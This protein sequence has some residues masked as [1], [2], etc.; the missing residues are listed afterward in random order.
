MSNIKE[1]PDRSTI[2]EEAGA[3][4]IKLD[5]DTELSLE[6]RQAFKE[7]MGRSPVHREAVKSL[8]QFWGKM[9]VLTELAMPQYGGTSKPAPRPF[10]NFGS[11]TAMAA[12]SLCLVAVILLLQI[13]SNREQTAN[14]LYATAV[15]QQQTIALDDGSTLQLNTNSQVRVDYS[16]Q[17]R[18]IHLLQG[19]AHFTVAKQASRPF[20]VSAGHGLVEAI[21]TA[22][23]VYL[24]NNDIEV[25]ISEGIV[26][27]QSRK[28]ADPAAT[29]QAAVIAQASQPHDLGKLKAGQ[30][31]VIKD[32]VSDAGELQ[33]VA[34]TIKDIS[35]GE[36]ERRL[37]WRKGFIT[38]S[39]APLD[40]VVDEIGRYSQLSIELTDPAMASIKIGGQFKVGEVDTMLESLERN[41]GL[42][43]RRVSYNHIQ[44]SYGE[45]SRTAPAAPQKTDE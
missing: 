26:G 27:L 15:G 40:Q 43:V 12:Y 14:G 30:S 7:W 37:S 22:F 4:I 42:K 6:Q 17:Y 20:R 16:D 2:D 29:P 33:S 5:G 28:P 9:N 25:T 31:A 21:G 23:S 41:F 35:P 11:K 3:W 8:A 45:V 34:A 19:E 10:F 32:I 38:F 24:N 13:N 36:L 44:L 18:D 1:L 39:G